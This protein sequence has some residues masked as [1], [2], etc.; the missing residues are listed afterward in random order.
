MDHSQYSHR[1]LDE[2]GR[3]PWPTRTN[4]LYSSRRRLATVT[5]RFSNNG[6]D[7][8]SGR[9]V[10]Q[11]GVGSVYHSRHSRDDSRVAG[12][13]TPYVVLL[14]SET[15]VAKIVAISS[16]VTTNPSGDS[17]R[18]TF[19]E[20]RSSLEADYGKAAL[21]F[22]FFI[23]R[24]NWNEPSD[25]MMAL[26]S[27]ERIFMATWEPDEDGVSLAEKASAISTGTGYRRCSFGP[28]LHVFA[29]NGQPCVT[30][31]RAI[32]YGD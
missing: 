28:D 25:W 29:G 18:D 5:G 14:P 4:G 24:S 26:L 11:I 19:N 20:L 22:D 16:D 8:H 13:C 9:N 6:E 12:P 3:R 32:H 27:H 23:P 1:V 15:G 21:V 17:L 30:N 10:G 7:K 31:V 2:V